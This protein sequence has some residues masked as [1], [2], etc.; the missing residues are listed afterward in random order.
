[1]VY[2]ECI[3]ITPVA[4][5]HRSKSTE[6]ILTP[7][8]VSCGYLSLVES[9]TF[10]D[11]SAP[12]FRGRRASVSQRRAFGSTTPSS[13]LVGSFNTKSSRKNGW[14]AGGL[15]NQGRSCSCL[16]SGLSGRGPPSFRGLSDGQN[17]MFRN[18]DET[19]FYMVLQNHNT[20]FAQ[21]LRIVSHGQVTF[22]RKHCL[23]PV[24]SL[25]CSTFHLLT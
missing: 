24:V 2:E 1:M 20:R 3:E 12:S 15:H 8:L 6:S 11:I 25:L 7:P 9:K 4:N 16:A 10:Q 21:S 18:H 17:G 22:P 23:I 13:R 14:A 19:P 5:P